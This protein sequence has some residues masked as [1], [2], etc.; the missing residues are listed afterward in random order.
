[1]AEPGPFDDAFDDV[2]A[3]L[4]P[5]MVII[6]TAVG[7]DRAGCLVGFHCQCSIEPRRYAVWLSKANHTVGVALRAEHL[8]VHFL[9]AGD[10]D[11]AELFGTTTGTE[12]DK[13]TRCAWSPGPDGVPLLDRIPNRLVLR[14]TGLLDEGSDHICF[15]GAPVDVGGPGGFDPL[16]L[17][18]V[19]DLEPGHEADERPSS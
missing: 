11:L 13:F 14:R 16:R 19:D 6:T 17:T 10:R 5:S 2:V 3:G 12:I 7:D 18:E 15:A 8:A 9:T 1:V 4:D